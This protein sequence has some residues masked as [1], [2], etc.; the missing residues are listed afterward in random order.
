MQRDKIQT[1]LKKDS[2]NSVPLKKAAFYRKY[3]NKSRESSRRRGAG[4]FLLR[5][6]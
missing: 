2:E 6:S 4:K 5:F 1:Q 3:H